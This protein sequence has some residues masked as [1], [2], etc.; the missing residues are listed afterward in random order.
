MRNIGASKS[1][2]VQNHGD[3]GGVVLTKKIL[4]SDD[5]KMSSRDFHPHDINS[6]DK[7]CCIFTDFLIIYFLLLKLYNTYEYFWLLFVFI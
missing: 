6:K 2:K 5:Q 3:A 7:P 1:S 4:K